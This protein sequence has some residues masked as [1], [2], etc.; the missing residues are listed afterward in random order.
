MT[1]IVSRG[2]RRTL[3][4]CDTFSGLTTS[5]SPQETQPPDIISRRALFLELGSN[6]AARRV[7][8][9]GSVPGISTPEPLEASELATETGDQ[10]QTN[11]ESNE[12]VALV[13][14]RNAGSES[15]PVTN[16]DTL[17]EQ[18]SQRKSCSLMFMCRSIICCGCSRSHDPRRKRFCCCCERRNLPLAFVKSTPCL[19]TILI[20][21]LAAATHYLFYCTWEILHVCL[22]SLPSSAHRFFLP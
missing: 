4:N 3:G 16:D 5:H 9:S 1:E 10:S 17:E 11:V 8:M 2:C 7:T 12:A 18:P 20:P 6:K 14:D 22:V 19:A 15:L 21:L 13:T